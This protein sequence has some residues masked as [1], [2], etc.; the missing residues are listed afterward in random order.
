MLLEKVDENELEINKALRNANQPN[1]EIR[2]I[3]KYK[4]LLKEEKKKM[5][6]MVG[7]DAA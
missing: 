4:L 1:E 2:I 6:I 3:K 7:E 5:V